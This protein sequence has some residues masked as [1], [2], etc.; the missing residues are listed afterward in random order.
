MCFY[1]LIRYVSIEIIDH[2]T[3]LGH[4]GSI[5]L[6]LINFFLFKITFEGYLQKTLTSLT[7]LLT[8]ELIKKI[9]QLHFFGLFTEA[10]QI[11]TL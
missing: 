6:I 11:L 3:N 1:F 4:I 7:K 8:A 5:F 9:R 2:L 10:Q